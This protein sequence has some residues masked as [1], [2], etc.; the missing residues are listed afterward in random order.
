MRCS[1]PLRAGLFRLPARAG[2]A[3]TKPDR[4]RI[5]RCSVP[6]LASLLC[7]LAAPAL[8]DYRLCNRTA[9][10]LD[11][12]LAIETDGA[13]ATKGWFR[14]L[15]GGCR[16]MLSGETEGD[17]FFLHAETPRAYGER[18]E[19]PDVARML[20]VKEGE[21]LLSGAESCAGRQGRLA[22]FTEV[23]DDVAGE[24]GTTELNGPRD[25][26]AAGARRAGLVLLLALAGYDAAMPGGVDAALAS[27][28]ADAGLDAD[29]ADDDEKIFSALLAAA[30]ARG[31]TQ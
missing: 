30:A 16:A 11:A 31:G 28:C 25:M 4:R 6:F 27:F 19:T 13:T 10:V 29:A 5:S 9:Y 1:T 12:A 14:V 3:R 22:P 8:A 17:R 2:R 26:D 21:F 24:A 7:L 20:C 15:P 18:S 23:T